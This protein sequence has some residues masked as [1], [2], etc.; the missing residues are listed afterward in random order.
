M[1]EAARQ[2]DVAPVRC[3]YVGDDERD[4]QAGIAAGMHVIVAKYGYLG[5]GTTPETWQAHSMIEHPLEL[6]IY[7][8]S[9]ASLKIAND[10]L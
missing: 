7:L 5:A 4:M 2:L 3:V 10:L 6:L 9:A 8:D 1:L